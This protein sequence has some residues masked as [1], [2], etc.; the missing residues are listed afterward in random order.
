MVFLGWV[1]VNRN[2]GNRTGTPK[3]RVNAPGVPTCNPDESS[4]LDLPICPASPIGTE[5]GRDPSMNLARIPVITARTSFRGAAVASLFC[6][7]FAAGCASVPHR[8]EIR[9]SWE[10]VNRPIVG[11]NT[12]IDD[13]ALGPVARGWKKITP[14]PVRRSIA[15]VESNLEFPVRFLSHL[16][17]AE[18]IAAGSELGRFVLNSTLGIAGIFDPAAEA[19]LGV[20]PADFG[21]MFARWGIPPGPYIVVPIL[22]PSTPR[23]T[24]GDILTLPLDPLFWAGFY[25]IPID[26]LFAI[27]DRARADDAIAQAKESALDFYVFTRDAFIQRRNREIRGE[28]VTQ[29]NDGET[30][31]P[32]P[33]DLYDAPDERASAS[34]PKL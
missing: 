25:L 27:N 31:P 14:G 18:F 4:G 17:Q 28:Y 13:F 23:E 32:F 29:P 9:D 7:L 8:Q 3:G 21:T 30:E 2:S 6:V 5:S 16:G 26:V 22:G 20:I 10:P 11:V 24:I 19:G 12:S 1:Q 15:N 33:P 34:S